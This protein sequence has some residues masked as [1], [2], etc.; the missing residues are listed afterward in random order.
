MKHIGIFI[1]GIDHRRAARWK[2][3]DRVGVLGRHVGH[4]AHEFLVFALGV[5]D[6]D[7]RRTRDRGE[8][9]RFAAM[10]HADFDDGELVRCAQAQQRQR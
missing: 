8:L 3:R 7:N 6:D 9:R 2:R 10:V 1:I 4:C 5:G